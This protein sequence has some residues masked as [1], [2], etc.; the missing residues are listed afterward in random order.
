MASLKIFAKR[1]K[2]LGQRV[3]DNAP[4]IVRR[5]ALATDQAV[6]LATPV[7]TGR[8]RSNWIVSISPSSDVV[9]AP[10]EPR[11]PFVEGSAGST[12]AANAQAAI[13]QGRATIG[14]FR[15]GAIVIRNNVPYI[16]RL[17]QG[18]SAQAPAMFVERA[19]RL[20]VNEVFRSR[21]LQQVRIG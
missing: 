16:R 12:G 20:G 2:Q 7:D 6:V 1:M 18:S 5:A 3:E 11:E 8:A 4:A 10:T 13:E 17:N 14:A 21:L 15:Q 19:A 9:T